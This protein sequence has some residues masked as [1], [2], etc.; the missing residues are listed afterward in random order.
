MQ[1]NTMH[2]LTK[3]NVEWSFAEHN[4]LNGKP[5]CM[6]IEKQIAGHPIKIYF[7]VPIAKAQD[8]VRGPAEARLPQALMVVCNGPGACCP[9][10]LSFLSP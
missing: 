4:Y 2:L 6:T 7:R 3:G 10:A 1:T 9:G 8:L 5:T